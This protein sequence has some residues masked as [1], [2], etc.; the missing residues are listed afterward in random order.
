MSGSPT[1]PY[2]DDSQDDQFDNMGEDAS[3]AER[4]ALAEEVAA[5]E[6]T[7]RAA[8]DATSPIRDLGAGPPRART[9]KAATPKSTPARSM[10]DEDEDD[11]GYDDDFAPTS[12][13]KQRKSATRP[14]QIGSMVLSVEQAKLMR[15]ADEDELMRRVNSAMKGSKA[16]VKRRTIDVLSEPNPAKFSRERFEAEKLLRGEEARFE[17][18]QKAAAERESAEKAGVDGLGD[19]GKVEQ[20]EPPTRVDA[21][22]QNKLIRKARRQGLPDNHYLGST[23]RELKRP[24]LRNPNAWFRDDDEKNC[25]F[26]PQTRTVES[27]R[28][29]RACGYEFTNEGGKKADGDAFVERLARA[30]RNQRKAKEDAI[31]KQEYSYRLDKKQ[32]PRCGAIQAY[33]EWVERFSKGKNCQECSIPYRHKKPAGSK[34]LDAWLDRQDR[35]EKL[36]RERRSQL[37]QK[38][39][40]DLRKEEFGGAASLNS[41]NAYQKALRAKVEQGPSF[42][43]RLADDVKR[44]KAAKEA[45]A[46]ERRA[47]AARKG[48]WEDDL[49]HFLKEAAVLE[50]PPA[51]PRS[52]PAKRATVPKK[53]GSKP[54]RRGLRVRGPGDPNVVDA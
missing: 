40:S 3:A 4:A 26:Q 13:P 14:L 29:Q 24:E 50:A 53:K 9:P 38:H 39:E 48:A 18:E 22:T 5:L 15:V 49:A 12:P 51:R 16:P 30:N 41:M 2:G 25:T 52:A 20:E 31:G 21:V 37:V 36:R 11:G 35:E 32:C 17:K 45:R 8:A 28:A 7:A 54:R 46:A 23:E 33:D 6:R 10:V 44:R 34:G 42:M 1:D 47:P 27:L 19:E 43:E